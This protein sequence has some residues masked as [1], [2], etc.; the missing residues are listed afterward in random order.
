MIF[1]IFPRKNSFIESMIVK[2]IFKSY[3]RKANH[4]SA[5]SNNFSKCGSYLLLNFFYSLLYYIIII[6]SVLFLS[7]LV[8][9]HK[10]NSRYVF[11]TSDFFYLSNIEIFFLFCNFCKKE[12]LSKKSFF[13]L[14]FIR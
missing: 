12:L 10:C 1:Y 13:L 14:I 7:H 3:T 2:Y 8:F 11:V 5:A 9:L 6:M 4:I